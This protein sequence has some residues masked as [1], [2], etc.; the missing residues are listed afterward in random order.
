[1]L[2]QTHSYNI[3]EQSLEIMGL[4]YIHHKNIHNMNIFLHLLMKETKIIFN[5]MPIFLKWKD[6]G[7][8][9]PNK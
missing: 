7:L 3:Y 8:G 6:C 4:C 5:C 9:V 2:N 1:M